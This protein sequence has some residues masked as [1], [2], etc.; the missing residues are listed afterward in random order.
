MANLA[1]GY[2]LISIWEYWYG[3]Y[4][5]CIKLTVGRI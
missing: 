2:E 1:S 5:S 3:S 4:A